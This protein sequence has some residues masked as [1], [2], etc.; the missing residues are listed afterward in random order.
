[1]QDSFSKFWHKLRSGVQYVTHVWRATLDN[2]SLSI[3]NSMPD[4]QTSES[5]PRSIHSVDN[6]DRNVSIMYLLV[7]KDRTMLNPYVIRHF[8]VRLINNV[9][10]LFIIYS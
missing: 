3:E 6:R 10:L 5:N 8:K 4:T 2:A 9:L 1:L 7:L